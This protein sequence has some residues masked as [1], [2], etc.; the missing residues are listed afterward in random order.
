MLLPLPAVGGGGTAPRR[1][2]RATSVAGRAAP[3][4][5][6]T[7]NT[8][9]VELSSFKSE[10]IVRETEESIVKAK[11]DAHD[12][13]ASSR[14]VKSKDTKKHDPVLATKPKPTAVAALSQN[15]TEIDLMLEGLLTK[16]SDVGRKLDKDEEVRGGQSSSVTL[17][18]RRRGVQG[19]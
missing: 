12:T 13:G 17:K 6:K 18:S 19:W 14:N 9:S 5:D 8:A 15:N 2:K 3:K 4:G 10:P 16:K 1:S 7:T 11:V